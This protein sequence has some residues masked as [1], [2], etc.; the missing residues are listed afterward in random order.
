MSSYSRWVCRAHG[1][2][3]IEELIPGMLH[4]H[5]GKGKLYLHLPI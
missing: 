2:H 5:Y 4:L 1:L 3:L